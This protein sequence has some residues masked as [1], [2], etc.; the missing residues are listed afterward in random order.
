MGDSFIDIFIKW[1]QINDIFLKEQ[2]KKNMSDLYN[3]NVPY[4][5]KKLSQRLKISLFHSLNMLKENK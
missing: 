5:A 1:D 3:N 4:K 2:E